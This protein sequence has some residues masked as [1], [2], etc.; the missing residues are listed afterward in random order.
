[1]AFASPRNIVCI[2]GKHFPVDIL[3]LR[4]GPRS[5]RLK[6]V[7]IS[8][9]IVRIV[10]KPPSEVYG[11]YW[12]WHNLEQVAFESCSRLCDIE[13]WNFSE[14]RVL[15]SICVPASVRSLQE[16]S[17]ARS[18]KLACVTFAA[19]SQLT[20]I[21]ANAFCECSSLTSICLPASCATVDGTAF[22]DCAIS[23]VSVED[24][25]ISLSISESFLVDFFGFT[26]VRY[27]GRDGFVSIGDA[28]EV[29]GRSCFSSC[30]WIT[31]IEFE[32]PSHLR[33]IEALAATKCRGLKSIEIP[34]SVRAI[35]G[36]AFSDCM[37]LESV[38][39]APNSVLVKIGEEAFSRCAMLRSIHVPASV[40]V[41]HQRSFASCHSLSSFTFE[42]GSKLREIQDDTFFACDALK[43]ISFPPGLEKL[44]V[45]WMDSRHF[46][47]TAINRVTFESA[48][49]FARIL[50]DSPNALRGRFV[51]EVLGWD[52]REPIPSYE[53]RVSAKSGKARIV[54]QGFHQGERAE[55]DSSKGEVDQFT[56]SDD[57]YELIA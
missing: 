47:L 2:L 20:R 25:S 56:G 31:S 43:T 52:S 55:G 34:A 4:S 57:E 53:V 30:L 45:Y 8:C 54:C 28:I 37:D 32:A 22:A 17:F 44:S 9:S 12:A 49:S 6:S 35:G 42:G 27:F 23:A 21:D 10:R 15:R 18:G 51:M 39:F 1:L 11:S 46:S 16:E 13:S 36:G 41:L 7:C 33:E 48:A 40:E 24:V 5:Q 29:L 19:D 3:R 26:I 14:C 50:A 38:A